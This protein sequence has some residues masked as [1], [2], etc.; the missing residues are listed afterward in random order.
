[1]LQ[2][3]RKTFSLRF[4]K[5]SE[6]EAGFMPPSPSESIGNKR[7]DTLERYRFGPL[8]WRASKERKK[9]KAQ[10]SA[11]CNSGDS[12]IQIEPSELGSCSVGVDSCDEGC[13]PDSLTDSGNVRTNSDTTRALFE[14]LKIELTKGNRHP[15]VR[16]A[17]SDISSSSSGGQRLLQW[18]ASRKFQGPSTPLRPHF[19]SLRARRMRKSLSQ[20]DIDK[21]DSPHLRRKNKL[22]TNQNTDEERTSEDECVSDSG[23]SLSHTDLLVMHAANVQDSQDSSCPDCEECCQAQFLSALFP[24]FTLHDDVLCIRPSRFAQ[25]VATRIDIDPNSA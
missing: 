20:C 8:V 3:F 7:S 6:G 17:H 22:V 1:M 4:N 10:R 15:N 11:K 12:G 21:Y 24:T 25:A 5:K 16:R 23:S 14:R 18:G 9:T 2:K 13:A 19:G